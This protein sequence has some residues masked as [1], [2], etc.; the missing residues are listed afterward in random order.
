ML[1]KLVSQGIS[2]GHSLSLVKASPLACWFNIN[3]ASKYIPQSNGFVE[4]NKIN[5]ENKCL[6]F[7]INNI[8]NNDSRFAKLIG[9]IKNNKGNTPVYIRFQDKNLIT[10][11]DLY[12][13]LHIG[14]IIKNEMFDYCDIDVRNVTDFV[15]PN[16]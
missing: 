6:V 13:N 12:S 1:P 11:S 5:R 7:T 9:I 10:Y 8:V 16:N 4:S 14:E 3:N 2:S 15:F